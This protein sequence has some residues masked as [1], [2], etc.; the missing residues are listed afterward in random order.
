MGAGP[1]PFPSI[2]SFSLISAQCFVVMTT[3]FHIFVLSIFFLGRVIAAALFIH[4]QLFLDFIA[5]Y[6]HWNVTINMSEY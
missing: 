2:C 6:I 4:G 3:T 1:P 5:A